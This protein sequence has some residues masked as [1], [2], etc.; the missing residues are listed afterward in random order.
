MEI[1]YVLG[2]IIVAIIFFSIFISDINRKNYIDALDALKNDPFNP[3]FHTR[4]LITGRA[5]KKNELAVANDIRAIT[6]NAS[7]K[8]SSGQPGVSPEVAASAVHV[9]SLNERIQALKKLQ[10]SGL[11]SDEEF[12]QKRKEILD[13][14]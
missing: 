10:E 13:S 9:L 6:A 7:A 4:A 11:I 1:V 8:S 3:D 2:I 12:V 14:I 5:F